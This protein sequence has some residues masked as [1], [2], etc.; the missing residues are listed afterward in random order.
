M[1]V[2]RNPDTNSNQYT[3]PFQ[4]KTIALINI[5]SQF[6]II[7]LTNNFHQMQTFALTGIASNLIMQRVYPLSSLIGCSG[8]IEIHARCP[9]VAL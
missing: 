8:K 1:H 5:H 7:T 3:F 2:I 6:R 9:D 4:A